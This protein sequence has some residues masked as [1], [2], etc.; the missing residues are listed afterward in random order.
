MNGGARAPKA[1]SDRGGGG[2]LGERMTANT[3]VPMAENGGEVGL[4]TEITA[5]WSIVYS[6]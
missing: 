2:G 5:L 6:W 1:H 4:P 3:A